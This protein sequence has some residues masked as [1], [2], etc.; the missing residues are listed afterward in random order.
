MKKSSKKLNCLLL[1]MSFLL[2]ACSP[3]KSLTKDEIAKNVLDNIG[4]VQQYH[5]QINLNSSIKDL[6]NDIMTQD[7][8]T[9]SDITIDEK[10]MDSFGKIHSKNI[11]IVLDEEY[12]SIDE[13]AYLKVDG[14]NWEDVSAQQAEYFHHTDSF[15]TNLTPI[16]EIM[17]KMGDLE[18]TNNTFVLTFSG[19][20]VDVYQSFEAPYNLQ[21]GSV[22][23]QDI[24]QDI[25]V[26][27]EKENFLI[28][29]IKNQLTT[30]VS[31]NDLTIFI[32]QLYEHFNELEDFDIPQEIIDEATS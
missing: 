9:F 28:R 15:Y 24:Q 32:K 31:D 16:V 20:S 4:Q 7:N 11:D 19:K 1:V 8:E 30:Q 12:Y 10:T 26:I 6:K 13:N 14:G 3:K 25:E 23:P 5:V 21:F 22:E 2:I 17:S 18:E 27:I 29:S